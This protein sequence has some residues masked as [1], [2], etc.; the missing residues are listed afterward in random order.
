MSRS[1]DLHLTHDPTTK[2]TNRSQISKSL[3]ERWFASNMYCPACPSENLD[4]TPPN[5][6]VVDFICPRCDEKYQLKGMAHPFGAK[7]VDSAYEPK[8]RMIKDGTGPNFVFLR[9]DTE[10]WMVQDMMMV[11][12]HFLVPE[13]IEKRKP[14]GAGARRAGWVGSNILLGMMPADARLYIVRDF[15]VVAA[16]DVRGAWKRFEF[17]KGM[18]LES[19]GWLNDVLA[20]V[21]KIGKD[22]FTLQEVYGFEKELKGL[23]PGNFHVREKIRQQLQLLRDRNIV[24][25]IERGQYQINP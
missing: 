13:V 8:I 22:E 19:R 11:P 4:Q 21:R 25:F 5:E 16:D 18:R 14:L 12:K 9:Y 1:M 15:G 2:Y 20:V 17:L 7:I 3:T 6:K 10:K 23:H 24:T